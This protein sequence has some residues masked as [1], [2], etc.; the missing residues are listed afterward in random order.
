MFLIDDNFLKSVGFNV[1]TL[2]EDEK[3]KYIDQF[4]A[5]LNARISN[6]FVEELDD[7]QVVEFNDIQENSDRTNRWLEEFHNDY[8][9]NEAYLQ[10]L[11]NTGSET[12]AKR[13]YATAL[14]MNDAVPRYGEII[15]EELNN[16]QAQLHEIRE[17][18]DRAV[19]R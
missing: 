9:S 13:M 3:R 14:W 19:G 6:R 2:S 17:M 8:R 4:T 7:D 15:Q 10:L 18:A 16:Y 12:D 11:K 5:E 1:D